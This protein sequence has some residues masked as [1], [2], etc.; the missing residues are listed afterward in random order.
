METP[1]NET[2]ADELNRRSVDQRTKQAT[3]TKLRR[4]EDLC[5]PLASHTDVESAGNSE[6]SGWRRNRESIS[7]SHIR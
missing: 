3:D 7:H 6:A 4:V 1:A 2:S 5:F